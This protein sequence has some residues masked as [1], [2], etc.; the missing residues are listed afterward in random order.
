MRIWPACVSEAQSSAGLKALPTGN[1]G[2]RQLERQGLQRPGAETVG[3][4]CWR[5]CFR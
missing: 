2:G 5:P 4:L 3:Q 1:R